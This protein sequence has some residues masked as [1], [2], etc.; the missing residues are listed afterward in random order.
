MWPSIRQDIHAFEQLRRQLETTPARLER[1]ALIDAFLSGVERVPLVMD[2]QAILLYRGRTRQ[3]VRVLGDW[4]GY[5]EPGQPLTEIAA[6]GLYCLPLRVAAD[7]RLDYIFSV[8]SPPR[9]RLDPLNPHRI[10]GGF[11]P[12]SVLVMPAYQPAPEWRENGPVPAGQT[13]RFC[14]YSRALGQ[15]RTIIVYTPPG[16]PAQAPYPAVY[17]HDGGDYVRFACLPQV[18]DRLIALRRTRPFVAIGMTPRERVSEYDCNDAYVS[19]VADE[20]RPAIEQ[21]FAVEPRPERRAIMGASYGGLISLYIALR[22]PDVFGCVGGQSA[23]AS[24]R[25]GFIIRAYSASPRLSVRL[26]LI[27]GAFERHLDVEDDE[28][29]FLQANRRLAA[30]LRKR[31]YALSYAEYPEGH[32]WGLWRN[33]IGDALE[34]FWGVESEG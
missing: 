23:Y 28:S 5:R 33:H 2:G 8:G 11:G 15:R 26:H 14:W 9:L 24:R 7:A 18:A 22:R 20:L 13:I 34:Y 4:N 17:L 12:R 16:Y 3:V 31:G 25:D 19:F 27:V 1:Q 32:S 29:N 21:R 30:V 6:S 10:G